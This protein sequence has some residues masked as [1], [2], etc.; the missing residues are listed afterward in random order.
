MYSTYVRIYFTSY[1]RNKVSGIMLPCD[2]YHHQIFTTSIESLFQTGQLLPWK[3]R[4]DLQNFTLSGFTKENTI[5]IQEYNF[6]KGRV[7]YRNSQKHESSTVDNTSMNPRLF[8]ESICWFSWEVFELEI[9]PIPI[10]VSSFQGLSDEQVKFS[11]WP[12][13]QLTIDKTWLWAIYL[14]DNKTFLPLRNFEKI[15]N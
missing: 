2:I 13:H 6:D 5:S 3:Q 4:K 11:L 10:F 9:S 8:N 15:F 14:T 7:M 12:T 1:V